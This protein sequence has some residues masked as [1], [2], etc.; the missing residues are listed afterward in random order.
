MAL[1]VSMHRQ[2]LVKTHEVTKSKNTLKVLGVL[3]YPSRSTAA[4]LKCTTASLNNHLISNVLNQLLLLMLSM[5][6][7]SLMV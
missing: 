7:S 6:S 1:G 4:W 2:L 3:S 5:A